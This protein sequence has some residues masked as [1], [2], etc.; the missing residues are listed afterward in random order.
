MHVSDAMQGV[1]I[2]CREL[3]KMKL[4]G[5][6]EPTLYDFAVLDAVWSGIAQGSDAVRIFLATDGLGALL[7]ILNKGALPLQPVL[8]TVISGGQPVPCLPACPLSSY[9]SLHGSQLCMLQMLDYNC[10]MCSQCSIR[11]PTRG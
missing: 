8:L 9:Q 10:C 4:P 7:D 6:V 1:A 3:E 5:S 11:R 2:L